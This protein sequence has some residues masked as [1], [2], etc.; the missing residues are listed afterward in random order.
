M[1]VMDVMLFEPSSSKSKVSAK[2]IAGVEIPRVFLVTDAGAE[3]H[4]SSE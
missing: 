4:Y 2:V 3:M 1:F